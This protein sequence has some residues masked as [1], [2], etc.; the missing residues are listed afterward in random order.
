MNLAL[1]CVWKM[2]ESGLAE[3]VPLLW[4]PSS[5]LGAL[6][7]DV[8]GGGDAGSIQPPPRGPSG[9]TVGGGTVVMADGCNTLC[10][11]QWQGDCLVHR[12]AEIQGR[13][14]TSGDSEREIRNVR[15]LGWGGAPRGSF[16]ARAPQTWG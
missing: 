11:L 13:Y 1:F 9:L 6:R 7:A 3:A 10:S 14:T 4:P 8:G 12:A 16:W 2:Q 5:I 15:R